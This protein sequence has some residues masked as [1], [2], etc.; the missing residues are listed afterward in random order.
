[1]ITV[2]RFGVDNKNVKTTSLT[3]PEKSISD[4]ENIFVFEDERFVFLHHP[5]VQQCLAIVVAQ[6]YELG[7]KKK[8]ERNEI[9]TK[10]HYSL[11]QLKNLVIGWKKLKTEN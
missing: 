4:S 3:L 5:V 10:K 1:V 2:C 8:S 9:T 11:Y 6:T 7:L